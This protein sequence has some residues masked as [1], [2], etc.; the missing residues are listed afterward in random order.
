M[1]SVLTHP[2]GSSRL[3]NLARLISRFGCQPA[4]LPRLFGVGLICLLRQPIFAYEQF[5]YGQKINKQPLPE[6]PVFVIG[7]WR[8]G[9]THLQNLL[10]LDPQFASVTLREAAMPLD[11]LTL[12]K[13]IEKSFE[14]SIPK[15]RLMDNVA[16]AADSAWEEEL[17]LV[18]T[19][20]L[21]FY[22][23]SFFPKSNPEIFNDSI[24]FRGNQTALIE[25]W[26]QDY[27][28]FLKKVSLIK[29]GKRFLLKNPAN[30]ARINQLIDMFPGAKFI[31]IKRDPYQ[32]FRSTVD[33]YY[34]AQKEW[35][36]HKANREAII[37][38][39][40]ASY[41]LLMDAYYQQSPNIPA[42][43]LAEIRFED[44]EARPM[45][46]I[47]QV[48]DRLELPGYEEAA[49]PINAYLKRIESYQKNSH[50]ITG[51]EATAVQKK[52]ATCFER[53]GYPI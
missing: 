22:H 43:N 24:L 11:F 15:K 48:Y 14:K 42:N 23:V 40:L 9:T 39:V 30:T 46:T 47:S 18:S 12:G 3:T 38:H 41:P 34:K 10:S 20:P 27:V 6:N 32:V 28:W 26:R 29:N 44:L 33:L 13:R 17:A 7:H 25:Q 50:N 45:E 5:K 51:N 37:Q 31:H 49:P 4:Y 36:F 52:W 35:G 16:V 21:S 53:L 8:S 19:S 1:P 2:L